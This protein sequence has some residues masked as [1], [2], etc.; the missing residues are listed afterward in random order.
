MPHIAPQSTE[1]RFS[2]A[3][4]PPPII[5]FLPN[6]LPWVAT[7]KFVAAAKQ[8][9]ACVSFDL[10]SFSRKMYKWKTEHSCR[11]EDDA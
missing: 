6:S 11:R 4:M 10:Y 3:T 8:E 7:V 2:L 5:V 1:Y 9:Q